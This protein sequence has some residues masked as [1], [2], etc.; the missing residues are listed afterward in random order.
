MSARTIKLPEEKVE[1][2]RETL[3]VAK[4]ARRPSKGT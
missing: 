3:A 2:M 4:P 1:K